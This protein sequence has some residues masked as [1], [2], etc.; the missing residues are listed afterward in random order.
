MGSN[1]NKP[2]QYVPS[3]KDIVTRPIP[4]T[5]YHDPI[6]NPF[7]PWRTANTITDFASRDPYRQEC[8]VNVHD[9]NDVRYLTYDEYGNLKLDP[10]MVGNTYFMW[11]SQTGYHG[12][13]IIIEST[14]SL[15]VPLQSQALVSRE[16]YIEGIPQNWQR[17]SQILRTISEFSYSAFGKNIWELSHWEDCYN[18]RMRAVEEREII[19]IMVEEGINP[20]T[21]EPIELN[22]HELK[23][24]RTH[25]GFLTWAEWGF[26]FMQAARGVVVGT[27]TMASYMIGGF[28][29]AF[30]AANNS[31][32]PLPMKAA[33]FY[34]AFN[35]RTEQLIIGGL[36][37]QAKTDPKQLVADVGFNIAAL[38]VA[39]GVLKGK[40]GGRIPSVDHVVPVTLESGMTGGLH[41]SIHFSSSTVATVLKGHGI[42]RAI[43]SSGH[44]LTYAWDKNTLY[45]PGSGVR[46]NS[47]IIKGNTI[48]DS[49]KVQEYFSAIAEIDNVDPTFRSK[50]KDSDIDWGDVYYEINAVALNRYID[51]T[52]TQLAEITMRVVDDGITTSEQL[53]YHSD[54]TQSYGRSTWN[55]IGINHIED[56]LNNKQKQSH[57]N[58][59]GTLAVPTVSDNILNFFT[60]IDTHSA[61]TQSEIANYAHDNDITT[62][63]ARLLLSNPEI[64]DRVK[65][66]IELN[67]TLYEKSFTTADYLNIATEIYI[68]TNLKTI[69]NYLIQSGAKPSTTGI[70]NIKAITERTTHISPDLATKLLDT[71][72]IKQRML[73]DL[74]YHPKNLDLSP[75]TYI[76]NY[77]HETE[78]RIIINQRPDLRNPQDIQYT[79]LNN[80]PYKGDTAI[81]ISQ[82][83]AKE[84][85][86]I[87]EPAIVSRAVLDRIDT[88]I[89]RLN[90]NGIKLKTEVGGNTLSREFYQHLIFKKDAEIQ[91]FGDS[92]PNRNDIS[93]EDKLGLWLFDKGY[94]ETKPNINTVQST[95]LI[96]KLFGSDKTATQNIPLRNMLPPGLDDN[97]IR[98][99]QTVLDSINDPNEK[100]MVI[101][102]IRKSLGYDDV[103]QIRVL[104]P[105]A[106][107]SAGDGTRFTLT[108][109]QLSTVS[110]NFRNRVYPLT[111][112]AKAKLGSD[113]SSIIPATTDH[114]ASS[115]TNYGIAQLLYQQGLISYDTVS[116]IYTNDLIRAGVTIPL[117]QEK[118]SARYYL[119]E[120]NLDPAIFPKNL[121]DYLGSYEKH[122]GSIRTTIDHL[123]YEIDSGAKLK[124]IE[125]LALFRKLELIK[126]K[127]PEIQSYEAAWILYNYKIIDDKTIT[128]H[129]EHTKSKLAAKGSNYLIYQLSSPES[130]KF[131]KGPFN[132]NPA[133]I[134][135]PYGH[136]TTLR[137]EP[138]GRSSLRQ[139][140]I[141]PAT[142]ANVHAFFFKPTERAPNINFKNLFVENPKTGLY[143]PKTTVIKGYIDLWQTK[144]GST[145]SKDT[146]TEI[147]AYV[148]ES[149]FNHLKDNPLTADQLN[150][151]SIQ[152]E[153][154]I[155]ATRDINTKN[156]LGTLLDTAEAKAHRPLNADIVSI[157]YIASQ[158]AKSVF[159]DNYLIGAE[160]DFYGAVTTMNLPGLS[161]KPY[162][163]PLMDTPFEAGVKPRLTGLTDIEREQ[164]LSTKPEDFDRIYKEYNT[165]YNLN[166]KLQDKQETLN[167][168][169]RDKSSGPADT[170]NA[171]FGNP[172]EQGV[173]FNPT[174]GDLLLDISPIE[175]KFYLHNKD[176]IINNARARGILPNTPAM[177]AYIKQLTSGKETLDKDL[178]WQSSL[179]NA[180]SKVKIEHDLFPKD[181]FYNSKEGTLP[182]LSSDDLYLR[183][184]NT[185]VIYNSATG[186][187][188]KAYTSTRTNPSHPSARFETTMSLVEYMQREAAQT[189]PKDTSI[190]TGSRSVSET[191]SIATLAKIAGILP[192]IYGGKPG[193]K[194]SMLGSVIYDIAEF[195][196][197]RFTETF[198]PKRFFDKTTEA[199]TGNYIITRSNDGTVSTIDTDLIPH[200]EMMINYLNQGTASG[201]NKYRPDIQN[202][203]FNT[204]KALI[205]SNDSPLND[206]IN[207][208]EGDKKIRAHTLLE[209]IQD[210]IDISSET[211]YIKNQVFAIRDST[212]LLDILESHPSAKTGTG[213]TTTRQ[214]A[215]YRQYAYILDPAYSK[216]AL[217]HPWDISTTHT[218]IKSDTPQPLDTTITTTHLSLDPSNKP[219]LNKYFNQINKLLETN[220]IKQAI[221][222]VDIVL[223]MDPTNTQL[224]GLKSTLKTLQKETTTPTTIQPSTPETHS[225]S[226]SL[227]QNTFTRLSQMVDNSIKYG[228]EFLPGTHITEMGKGR[229]SGL[230]SD[231]RSTYLKERQNTLTNLFNEN[232]NP[233]MFELLV[234]TG[235][236]TTEKGLD[237]SL[238][239]NTALWD[240]F[241]QITNDPNQMMRA[242]LSDDPAQTYGSLQMN[243][244]Y[245]RRLDIYAGRKDDMSLPLLEVGGKPIPIGDSLFH[246]AI[247]DVVEG[248]H[249]KYVQI[250]PKTKTNLQ[251]NQAYQNAL[252]WKESVG[253]DNAKKYID[254]ANK[255][256]PEAYEGIT[257]QTILKN[258][259][260]LDEVQREGI[261]SLD[262]LHKTP[263][264][265]IPIKE[266]IDFIN[267][268]QKSDLATDG[269]IQSIYN[270]KRRLYEP[271]PINPNAVLTFSEDTK[272]LKPPE[273]YSFDHITDQL[274]G[275]IQT[276][277]EI[278]HVFSDAE[279]PFTIPD[280]YTS[281]I[282]KSDFSTTIYQKY[283]TTF[284][285]AKQ[286]S[287]DE[288]HRQMLAHG[289]VK[290]ASAEIPRIEHFFERKTLSE[291]EIAQY[292]TLLHQIKNYETR[293]QQNAKAKIPLPE[294]DLLTRRQEL[295][296]S[297]DDPHNKN[298]N[299]LGTELKDIE[300][301]LI[302]NTYSGYHIPASSL[303]DRL[304]ILDTRKTELTKPSHIK[305]SSHVVSELAQ[306]EADTAHIK[307][308]LERATETTSALS[309]KDEMTLVREHRTAYN[310]L[311]D[312]HTETQLPAP[313][314]FALI[315]AQSELQNAE[316]IPI[317]QAKLENHRNDITGILKQYENV[318]DM[319]DTTTLSEYIQNHPQNILALRQ[320]IEQENAYSKTIPSQNV[321]SLVDSG[322]QS[323][324]L[325]PELWTRG[326]RS[327]AETIASITNTEWM[328]DEEHPITKAIQFLNS[329]KQKILP[330]AS[331]YSGEI[332][333][334]F[335]DEG[336]IETILA[337]ESI[338]NRH[339]T[340][341]AELHS[342]EWYTQQYQ[343][344]PEFY[345]GGGNSVESYSNFMGKRDTI[346]EEFQTSLGTLTRYADDS[347]EIR[348]TRGQL[349]AGGSPGAFPRMEHQFRDSTEYNQDI[350]SFEHTLAR[351][352]GTSSNP[353]T[354]RH[355]T[356]TAEL[357]SKEWYTQQ[358]QSDPEFYGGGGE[359]IE[360]YVK[361][362]AKRNDEIIEEFDTAIG[363]MTRYADDSYE[364][365]S[366]R[367]QLTAGGSAGAYSRVDPITGKSL[368]NIRKQEAEQ[369]IRDNADTIAAAIDKNHAEKAYESFNTTR[370]TPSPISSSTISTNSQIRT[371]SSGYD[372]HHSVSSNQTDYKNLVE[373][374]VTSNL[375]IPLNITLNSTGKGNRSQYTH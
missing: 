26:I 6:A 271:H 315:K 198:Y 53:K 55:E 85:Y 257:I 244:L 298:K 167:Q 242:L 282:P 164:I 320:A 317:F 217:K 146:S 333:P 66:Y 374:E 110:G 283:Q 276:R 357:H 37:T 359:S 152:F 265:T 32:V 338:T 228:I 256:M 60:F 21:G 161:D 224:L 125:R 41:P 56:V 253:V 267:T 82:W 215:L 328:D 205:G 261:P 120:A 369:A 154:R 343:S 220:N 366:T 109:N 327:I 5:S 319:V 140:G 353:I 89:D 367:G 200:I 316:T 29:S 70:V 156:P 308:L 226:Q 173:T 203:Q 168:E 102:T 23:T 114:K 74:L 148:T 69:E 305:K 351:T 58:K 40:T 101:Y 325:F 63:Q 134:I 100:I 207:S 286:L 365:R 57:A 186:E 254:Y 240:K 95:S 8:W 237:T 204:I 2:P 96:N 368:K 51:L 155:G 275:L 243:H 199:S 71:N 326:E 345:G 306:I 118:T 193:L 302:Q 264:Q 176:V 370:T 116:R 285:Q 247:L 233:H 187:V 318:A 87:S 170:E 169:A 108:G 274:K 194:T 91:K 54:N 321:Q 153:H 322:T 311:L 181:L 289:F 236:F 39:G 90:E 347:Y 180:E 337:T 131:E 299:A 249:A 189:L 73:N 309:N 245:N 4:F 35:K 262:T 130:A 272:T 105:T 157:D 79:D 342:K 50:F 221:Q 252:A 28:E 111:P 115:K 38:K 48:T 52:E 293:L 292:N 166:K 3:A 62:S 178:A 372:I 279:P 255:H 144:R 1:D 143:H 263:G 270:P 324:G 192:T 92:L 269:I 158:V 76:R 19:R 175:L 227:Q 64:N 36:T 310:S 191:L 197:K 336:I 361:F 49:A 126:D 362:M 288:Y 364:I 313:H 344:D 65:K 127:D 334:E 135:D 44:T 209:S 329:L 68:D 259:L 323:T 241:S 86:I 18:E 222:L 291:P 290:E 107:T 214:L 230:L 284:D 330:T 360:S 141:N 78:T 93:S 340:P 190:P 216:D 59:A 355:Q 77:I 137:E 363:T 184:V 104:E 151:I 332:L 113:I 20:Y 150:A 83:L 314:K 45:T 219:H 67:P 123:A 10:E 24:L 14:T 218:I 235:M 117:T 210:N 371:M 213:L 30:H 246:A 300:N 172:S 201:K 138:T 75:E 231:E 84:G 174:Y 294:T 183:L 160:P 206:L 232:Q 42:Y 163:R 225:L 88:A 287:P 273:P 22:P 122:D 295:I 11:D 229:K 296:E 312:L 162:V 182:R 13:T 277:R 297:I 97:M 349:T 147:A 121:E 43:T 149:Y 339:Q 208:L 258:A 356:P 278:P 331:A 103:D 31:D 260:V 303:Q 33:V 124:Q 72:T 80:Q 165:L 304:A 34:E 185:Q 177:E 266:V 171:V 348:S 129:Y 133:D 132:T 94:A 281:T 248:H 119:S 9:Q 46:P 301:Q 341:T 373:S 142:L 335:T 354:N 251:N 268:L 195:T 47:Y 212:Q 280:S 179:D 136:I 307:S 159:E 145:Q 139:S 99:A 17:D 81:P 188:R 61:K 196:N 106:I 128:K 7:Q 211:P 98:E 238:Y 234:R 375:I 350:L 352:Y 239:R 346:L 250:Y 15:K 27:A 12:G 16:E 112:E 223:S 202:R 358:Y 25:M